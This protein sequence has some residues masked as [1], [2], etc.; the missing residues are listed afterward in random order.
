MH[1]G[2]V[3]EGAHVPVRGPFDEPAVSSE[4][5]IATAEVEDQ[6]PSVNDKAESLKVSSLNIAPEHEWKHDDIDGPNEDTSAEVAP[7]EEAEEDPIEEPVEECDRE[8]N[9]PPGERDNADH[10]ELPYERQELDE[11]DDEDGESFA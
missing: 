9:G 7:E 3:P 5:E 11:N 4:T 10:S 6:H 2:D 8:K 1:D